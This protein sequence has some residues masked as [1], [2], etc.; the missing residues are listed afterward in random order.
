MLLKWRRIAGNRRIGILRER[1]VADKIII[2]AGAPWSPTLG[3]LSPVRPFYPAAPAGEL[4][5]TL[6]DYSN[7]RQNA[8]KKKNNFR[9]KFPAYLRIFIFI[10]AWHG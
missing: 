5:A 8:R 7:A 3:G 1:G 4:L 2:N 6:E 9:A 10:Y